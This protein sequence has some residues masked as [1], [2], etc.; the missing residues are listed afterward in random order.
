MSCMQFSVSRY[1]AQSA[2]EERAIFSLARPPNNIDFYFFFS[3]MA[4]KET[5]IFMYSMSFWHKVEINTKNMFE[6]KAFMN[7]TVTYDLHTAWIC[8]LRNSNAGSRLHLSH[9]TPI[10]DTIFPGYFDVL[11][12]WGLFRKYTQNSHWSWSKFCIAEWRK[13]MYE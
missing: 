5:V 7:N 11:W 4:V 12:E 1:V 10:A 2:L 8:L 6:F 3:T 13:R 9:W